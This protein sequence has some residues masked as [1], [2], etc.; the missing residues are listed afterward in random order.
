MHYL[1]A[2]L[3]ILAGS[4]SLASCS[5]TFYGPSSHVNFQTQG[6]FRSSEQKSN[7]TGSEN[8]LN[9]TYDEEFVYDDKGNILKITQTEYIDRLATDKKF[10]VWTTQYKVVGGQVVPSFMTINGTP[11]VEVEWEVLQ[12]KHEGPIVQDTIR[13]FG[14]QINLILLGQAYL[15]YRVDL[16]VYPVSF[17]ED[18]KFVESIQRIGGGSLFNANY[19]TLG[20]NNI[21]LKRFKYDYEALAAGLS[22]TYAGINSAIAAKITESGNKSA[23]LFEYEWKVI[24]DKIC[25]VS[26]LF[27]S[28]FQTEQVIFN[29][30]LEHNASGD[31]TK[32]VWTVASYSK[33]FGDKSPMVIYEQN[34]RY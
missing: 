4:I 10:F 27:S 13:R 12:S 15:N 5:S 16:D 19:L 7:L 9:N 29:A 20:Y 26:T 1:K 21:V 23:I 3:L 24:A 6:K 25:Q 34:L 18:D 17:D 11:F 8:S 2:V 33:T 22:K 14:N 30:K 31:R 32:E 28:R